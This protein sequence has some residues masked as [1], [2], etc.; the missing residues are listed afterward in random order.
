MLS[1]AVAG[2]LQ[3]GDKLIQVRGLKQAREKKGSGVVDLHTIPLAE[4]E[5]K[6][7][8]MS[9][10]VRSGLMPQLSPSM[11]RLCK[12][13]AKAATEV[14]CQSS[15]HLL[16]LRSIYLS[17]LSISVL[18][19]PAISICLLSLPSICSAA[20]SFPTVRVPLNS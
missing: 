10:V 6:L 15:L 7:A 3:I 20:S 13:A 18:C 5:D 17:A 14:C 4:L 2:G 9:E 19:L 11:Q 16:S 8:H 12:A 1:D